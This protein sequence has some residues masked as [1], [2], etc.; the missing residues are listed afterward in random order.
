MSMLS[1]EV[2]VATRNRA[3]VLALSVPL[4]L[5]Q[6]RPPQRVIVVDASD[7]HQATRLS[8]ERAVGGND[9]MVLLN[10]PVGLARQRNMA[11]QHSQAD[12]VF[13]PD[14]DALWYRDAAE[15]AMRIYEQDETGQIAGISLTESRTPSIAGLVPDQRTLKEKLIYRFS[16]TR[17]RVE[18]WFVKNPMTLLGRELLAAR[19][20]PAGAQ[21]CHAPV[22][23]CMRGFL[24]S[25]RRSIIQSIGFDET[26]AGY[27]LYEDYLA[28]FR[29][30]QQGLLVDAEDAK[31]FHHRA[32]GARGDAGTIGANLVLNYAYVVCAVSDAASPARRA[33]MPYFKIRALQ[34]RLRS[35]GEYGE[36]RWAAFS[37]AMQL[38]PGLLAASPDQLGAVYQRAM[39]QAAGPDPLHAGVN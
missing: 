23:P 2:L 1:Y 11:L 3:D 26:L 22:V 19:P 12:V 31:V 6:S 20:I 8:L 30:L 24:M 28:S 9:R 16:A 7:D 25:F 10:G 13:F 34:Y 15:H 35:R 18:Q 38:V 36:H 21:T 39:T 4:F 14:D 33:L 32:P 37:K 5:G 17:H 29:A 27:G